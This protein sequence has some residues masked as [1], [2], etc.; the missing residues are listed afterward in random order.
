MYELCELRADA[1]VPSG[2]P[3]AEGGGVVLDDSPP[4]DDLQLG[5][6]AAV[7]EWRLLPDE[8]LLLPATC[9][10]HPDDEDPDVPATRSRSPLADLSAAA[11][12]EDG[13]RG[14]SGGSA[15]AAAGAVVSDGDGTFAAAGDAVSDDEKAAP[16]QKRRGRSSR[17]TKSAR[18]QRAK[19]RV[20]GRDKEQPATNA[21]HLRGVPRQEL[22]GKRIV[23]TYNEDQQIDEGKADAKPSGGKELVGL[24]L[25]TDY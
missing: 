9:G 20:L 6:I 25:T 21:T 24:P 15:D 13:G 8:A 3:E 17:E 4:M 12:G 2:A 1:P 14:G 5:S 16:R 22:P 19:E 7:R 10:L 23:V 18:K 11:E